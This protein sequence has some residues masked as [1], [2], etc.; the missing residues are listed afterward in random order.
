MKHSTPFAKFL[1]VIAIA[2]TALC[3]SANTLSPEEA[4]FRA[5]Q[6]RGSLKAL[7]VSVS[8]TPR[9]VKTIKADNEPAVYLFAEDA[10]RNYLVV[11]ADDATDAVLGYGENFKDINPTMQWWLDEYANQIKWLRENPST[12]SRQRIQTVAAANYKPI[13]PMVKTQWNQSAPY[14]NDCPTYQKTQCVTGC[15]ATALAQVMK[16]H[17]WPKT[18]TGSISYTTSS[19]GL[20]VSANF[21]SMT[22]D[23]NDMLDTY[24]SDATDAQKNAVAQLMFACGAA[25]Q[26]DYTPSS[27]GASSFV[28]AIAMTQYFGYDKGITYYDR[29]LYGINDWNALVYNQLV[30]YGPVQYSGQS[31]S[32]G[33]SFVCD[34]YSSNGYF[35]F[36]WG[37][38]GMSDGYFLLTALDPGS[39]GIGGSTSGYNFLQD[40][41]G[42]VK[43]ATGNSDYVFNMVSTSFVPQAASVKLGNTLDF[44]IYTYNY[45]LTKYGPVYFGIKTINSNGDVDY[46][47]YNYVN[48]FSA[49]SY[50]PTVSYRFPT[51]LKAGTYKISPA[52]RIND[53][54]YDTPLG[55]GAKRV[56]TMTVANGTA[57]FG[58]YSGAN[59][60]VTDV[61]LQTAVYIGAQFEL[62]ATV[63]NTGD[64]EYVGSIQLVLSSDGKTATGTGNQY[65][66]D[67]LSSDSSNI[68]YVSKL[69]SASSSSLAAG[70][71]MGAFIDEEG[72]LI[73]DWF[74]VTVNAASQPTIKLNKFVVEGGAPNKFVT[75]PKNKINFEINIG[76]T[77]GYFGDNLTI[78][79]FP[80]PG[81]TSLASYTTNPFFLSAGQSSDMTMTVDFSNGEIGNEYFAAL[82]YNGAEVTPKQ[83]ACF[84]LGAPETSGVSDVEVSHEVKTVEYYNLSGVKISEGQAAAPGF[85]IVRKTMNDGT[86]ETNKVYVR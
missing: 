13:E 14:N 1:A 81:G 51:T 56:T 36:N 74:D 66:V 62:T 65:P 44:D 43:P 85:Y 31:N 45:S 67:I 69:S 4:L 54:W 59:L 37:W 48:T 23:W 20:S 83:T 17:E 39:Q 16:Y 75:V 8:E 21:S 24:G 41:I 60:E 79:V 25:S 47:Y 19:L 33:H 30:D 68:T 3:V 57:T 82:Y 46:L 70:T 35:H 2:S 42:N 49:G 11:S 55:V 63:S 50:M 76:A 86:V 10:S 40:I 52:V 64:R 15:V 9:L 32:G 22:F 38:G 73:S 34:G 5:S 29:N 7:N 84:I 61:Q 26:M 6:E 58:G 80:Y 71:Y 12:E 28:A 72:Y 18:G 27:S 53:V 78:Y 77:A